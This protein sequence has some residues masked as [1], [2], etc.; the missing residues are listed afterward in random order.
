M[1]FMTRRWRMTLQKTK[2]AKA[3]SV[4][5]PSNEFF[6]FTWILR[7]TTQKRVR[8]LGGGGG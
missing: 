8:Y 1:K 7:E 4:E 3:L 6:L 5:I 2:S